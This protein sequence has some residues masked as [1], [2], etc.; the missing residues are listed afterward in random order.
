VK[1]LRFERFGDP[2]VLA[3]VD[4]PRPALRDGEV[5]VAV[6][7]ASI[8]PSDV[9][10]V[11]GKME[12][13]TLPRTPGRDFSG[14]V[15]EGPVALIGAE[16]WGAGGDVGFTRDGSHAEYIAV[17][18][19]GVAKKPAKLSFLEAAACGVNF[20]T[21]WAGVATAAHLEA[22]E[23]ILVTGSAG[24]VGSS[25]VQLARWMG[26]RSIGVDRVAGR[27]VPRALAPD[28]AVSSSDDVLA[29]VRAATD[30]RGVDVVYDTVGAPL[31]ETNLAALAA[32]GRYVIIASAGER[33]A[34][35]DILDFYHKR[36]TLAG[37]DTR[38]LDT[39]ACAR[40]LDRL[41]PGF[42]AGALVAP[43]I[44]ETFDIAQA[45]EA[46]QAASGGGTGKFMLVAN[47][48]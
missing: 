17:P 1:A 19:D 13:T 33:R 34:S 25:V 39:V 18:A 24:G 40:I 8:N 22:G 29:A 32:R 4:V 46:Y 5:L 41:R 45:K 10:N 3:V 23:T 42:D 20:V 6:R 30:G 11:A 27:N 7:A 43:A 44:G 35:F 37:V 36:L 26:A 28:V 14:I 38:A 2:S 15:V 48:A 21:A 31:F 9:K 47:A 16:V 12:G